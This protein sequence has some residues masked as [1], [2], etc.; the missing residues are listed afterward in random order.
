MYFPWSR[1]YSQTPWGMLNNIIKYSHILKRRK[2]G[3]NYPETP[4]SPFQPGVSKVLGWKPGF[5][6]ATGVQNI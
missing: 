5:L 1:G 4:V 2:N 3:K 6:D